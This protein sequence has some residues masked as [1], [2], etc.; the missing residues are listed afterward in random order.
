MREQEY[1][2]SL[3]NAQQSL[4]ECVEIEHF[5]KAIQI[6]KLLGIYDISDYATQE[7]V[8]HCLKELLYPQRPTAEMT[9][10]LLTSA[11]AVFAQ[12]ALSEV[13]E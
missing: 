4:I 10:D 9:D 6:V 5:T 2:P 8:V 12:Y 13:D 7:K 11:T 1:L 3:D